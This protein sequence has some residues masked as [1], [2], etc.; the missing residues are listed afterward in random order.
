MRLRTRFLLP[1]FLLPFVNVRAQ[2]AASTV[3][4]SFSGFVKTDVMLDS[5]QTVAFR[6]GHFLLFPL[7][8]LNDQYGADINAKANLNIL[9]IQT[10]L[11][12]KITGPDALGAKTSS[13]IEGEFFGTSDAD[14]GGLRIRHAIVRLDW[15]RTSLLI[16][17]FWHPM[18]VA[19]MFPG[20]VSFNTGAPFQAFARS[21]QVRLTHSLGDVKVIVAA[22][23]QRDFQSSGPA[24]LSSSYLRNSVIPNF[25]AQLQY[26]AGGN[27]A[28]V[29][30]DYKSLTPRL[31]TTRNVATRTSIASVAIL[32]YAKLALETV[33]VTAE[34]T[35]GGNLSDLLMLGGYATRSVDTA[36]GRESY[37]AIKV[38]SLWG[39]I[40][41]GKE[42]EFALFGGYS[43][44]MGANDN[45]AGASYGRGLDIA[46]LLRI[47]P[48]VVWNSGKVRLSAEVE[49]TSAGYGTPNSQNKGRVEDITRVSNLRLLLA[50]Y[51]FF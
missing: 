30:V 19:E 36:S 48:R 51:D 39:E 32:G 47:S 2:E 10:R 13:L 25:H 15:K 24:G 5:R 1:C 50:I 35:Y 40:S 41:T 45:L 38:L 46:D 27:M 4:I 42:V 23:S 3:G 8:V 28:G 44:N 29:G 33:T 26:S 12:G 6:E 11:A 20:V 14:V 7:P 34:G 18:F 21:P 17:Q 22:M 37:S 49:Y 31:V 43:K 16:G 9:S